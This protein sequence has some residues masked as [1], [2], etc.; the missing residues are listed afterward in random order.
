MG[1]HLFEEMPSVL[2]R[3]AKSFTGAIE[4]AVKLIAVPGF[5]TIVDAT[6]VDTALAVSNWKVT[7]DAPFEGIR[8]PFVKSVK[9]SGA[10]P[11]RAAVKGEAYARI[12]GFQI[13]RTVFITNNVPYIVYLDQGSPTTVASNMVARGVQTMQK[14]AK[15]IRIVKQL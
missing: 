8:T 12:Q 1:N 2:D 6:P 10:G 11:A 7:L 9:G 3:Y 15:S 13:D 5:E 14:V 4:E